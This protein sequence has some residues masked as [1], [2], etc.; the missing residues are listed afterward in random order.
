MHTPQEFSEMS[1]VSVLFC[2]QM[3]SVQ[4][5]IDI[6][7]AALENDEV[8]LRLKTFVENLDAEKTELANKL[9]EEQRYVVTFEFILCKLCHNC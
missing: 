9:H 4:P 7:N 1:E 3:E 8:S 2:E 5:K 6:G